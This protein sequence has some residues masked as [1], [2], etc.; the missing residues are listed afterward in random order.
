[1]LQ[2]RI[3]NLARNQGVH[4]LTMRQFLVV[5]TAVILKPADLPLREVIIYKN[6]VGYFER[7]GDVPAGETARS[8]SKRWR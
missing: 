8:L 6:G 3:W 4:D 1:M 5:V 2:P 7:A